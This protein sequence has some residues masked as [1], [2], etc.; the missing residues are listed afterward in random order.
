MRERC[1]YSLQNEVLEIINGW[2]E[3][4]VADETE[5]EAVLSTWV[6]TSEN[7][8]LVRLDVVRVYAMQSGNLRACQ[9]S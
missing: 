1:I 7:V 9:A 4:S 8:S 2:L 3:W 6:V 5:E